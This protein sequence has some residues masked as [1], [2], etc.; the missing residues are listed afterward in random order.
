M[1]K[2]QQMK[3]NFWILIFFLFSKFAHAQVVINEGSNKNYTQVVDENNDKPDWIE[4]YNPSN[5]AYN[6][7]DH[8]LTDNLGETQK[9]ALPPIIMEPGAYKII[10]CSGKDR[11][12]SNAF[13]FS[14]S[15]ENY[16]PLNGWN[17]HNFNSIFV[18]DGV[19]NVV[20]NVCSYN[21]SQ[22]TL[23][24]IFNQSSTT[25]PSTLGAFV[26]G[27]PAAC[28]SNLGQLYFQRPNVKINGFTI[29]TGQIQN[30]NTEYPAPYGNYY[31]GARHQ[32]LFHASELLAAGL[33][34]GPFNN[35]AFDVVTSANEFYNYI[36]FSFLAT[37][38]TELTNEFLPE[39]GTKLH[40]NFK[41]DPLGETVYL[42]NANN[43]VISNLF[44][45]SPTTDIS[46]GHFPDA[47]GA[48]KWMIA[49]PKQSNNGTAI[50]NDTLKSPIFSKYSSV[51]TSA[52]LLEIKNPNTFPSKIVYTLDG[53]LPTFNSTSY[54]QSLLIDTNKVVNARI[55]PL[56]LSDYIPSENTAASYLF[57]VDH[58]TPILLLTTT[59]S[60]LYGPSGIFDNPNSDDIKQAYV[61]Y[62]D[63][64]ENHNLL[65]NRKT[66]IRMDGGAGGSRGNPQRSF[67][68]SLDHGAL[69]GGPV[70]QQLI[71]NRPNRNKFSDLY[72]RN[73]SNQ[74]NELPYKDASQ[75]FM[76][77]QGTENYYSGYR[78]VSVYVNG[79]Y[80]GLYELREKFNPEYFEIY[81]DAPTQDSIEII[82]LSYFYGSV[83]RAVEGKVENFLNS[84]D[85]FLNLSPTSN[86]YLEQ[87]EQY[88]DLKHYTDYIISESWMG[89][90]DWPHN[91]IKIYRS[92]KT[93][94]RWRFALIDLELCL[95]PNGWTSCTDN[96]FDYMLNQSPSNAYINIWLRSILNP[97]YKN[98]FINRFAD[99]IN[100]SYQTE[101][102]LAIE[103]AFFNGMNP[104]MPK[105]F[106]RWG[107][108]NEIEQQMQKFKN[109]HL[110][111]RN[112]LA[113]R[114]S[115]IQNQIVSTFNL[116]KKVAISL[117][118]FPED[119]GGIQLN[120]IQPTVYPWNGIYFDG[121]PINV[122]A[123]A[124]PG[125]QFS[126]WE[127]NAF[128]TDTLNPI[129]EGNISITNT[130]FKAIFTEIPDGPNISFSVFPNPTSGI[131][132]IQHDNE[133]VAK[134]CSFEI[135][136]LSGKILYV[137]NF[138]T[139]SL[140]TSVN[141]NAFRS[142]MYFIRIL[143]NNAFVETIRFVKQ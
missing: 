80:F 124:K 34:A 100:T 94:F 133:T 99:Q 27:S 71:P 19:S 116:E 126:H 129:F 68:L 36:D 47:S 105:Q 45:K 82:S 76:M 106:E 32:F 102:L 93:N 53:S 87:T 66:A 125:F 52:F 35:L 13:H 67:R 28:N 98:Y 17:T 120:T 127:P 57:N 130:N 54:T 44:V 70:N 115:V 110:T 104:E 24:S 131:L 26:D 61:S 64:G 5:T 84:Y 15:Q 2:W 112:Q 79:S 18:W 4:L 51:N 91:N 83:L 1:L 85:N 43:Q 109:N 38:L 89:N 118:V 11:I 12:E 134:E 86:N 73:G 55:F 59:N 90:I 141:V 103:Q 65:F 20:L 113:C 92:D 101:K 62:L 114:N 72:L 63:E 75:V 7:A 33:T 108:P 69:G 60:N 29:G 121:V 37:D 136:D 48:V 9:W 78:P 140:S 39:S 96:H 50:F 49:T 3:I 139:E 6:L 56:N 16:T 14:L 40:T 74:W 119:K 111:F 117:N 46:V 142:S 132:Q 41:I 25:F 23:N 122:K 77:S 10:H 97:T 42:I 30:A 107:N 58:T 123:I 143:R 128:I 88:F 137:G 22:Y 135:F 95:Q 8:F 31:W 81:N 21:N 138:S